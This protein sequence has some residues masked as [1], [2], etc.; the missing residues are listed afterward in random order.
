MFIKWHNYNIR[1]NIFTA[2]RAH[3]WHGRGSN[4]K[5]VENYSAFVDGFRMQQEQRFP[6]LM[7]RDITKIL[8]MNIN[9]I[10][11]ILNLKINDHIF[12]FFLNHLCAIDNNY[13]HKKF[14]LT[15]DYFFFN[16]LYI[17]IHIWIPICRNEIALVPFIFYKLH[18]FPV[19][20]NVMQDITSKTLSC[21]HFLREKW[22][23]YKDSEFSNNIVEDKII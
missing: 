2:F 9:D 1:P 7:N 17:Y 5:K 23:Y 11:K 15:N 6:T 10:T 16:Y 21:R 3:K 12:F 14:Y 22:S 13:F 18:I 19:I 8:H 4:V 20:Y